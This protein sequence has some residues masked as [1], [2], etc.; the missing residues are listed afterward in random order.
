MFGQIGAGK[1]FPSLP[2]QSTPMRVFLPEP[3]HHIAA[4]PYC[5]TA[6]TVSGEVC[7]LRP[8]VDS[9]L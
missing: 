6:A 8:P 7:V 3:V 1:E 5:C 2:V 9:R 4:G